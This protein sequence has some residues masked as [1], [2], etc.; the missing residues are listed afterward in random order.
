MKKTQINKNNSNLKNSNLFTSLP[1]ELNSILIG[2]ML[3]DGG[4]YRSSL[5]SNARL[6]MS[7]DE[8]YKSFAE[9]LGIIFKDYISNPVKTI[10]IK[11]K[12]KIYLN[13]R[14]KT[15]SSPIFN[16]YYEMFYKLNS[17]SH[18]YVKIVPT[19]IIDLVNPIVLAYLIMTDGN[20]DKS[21]NRIR[22][23]TNSFKKYEV[24]NLTLAI[25]DK[26]GI[27]TGVLHDRKDQ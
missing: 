10:E 26:L 5:T 22:I 20:F 4:M 16:Q 21:R 2:I 27:Y 19:N 12:D 1:V 23:Y 8:K 7:F 9:S 13:Y 25:N 3:G 11:G 15:V 18:K 24:Q 6:E 14:L 17:E